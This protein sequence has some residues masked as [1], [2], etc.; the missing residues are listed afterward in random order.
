MT[1]ADLQQA[2]LQYAYWRQQGLG[3]RQMLR[4]VNLRWNRPGPPSTIS[5]IVRLAEIAHEL[6]E[7]QLAGDLRAA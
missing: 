3:N 6:E 2:V 4:A 1:D 7:K 5:T